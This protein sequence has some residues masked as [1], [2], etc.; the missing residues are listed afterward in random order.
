MWGRCH[1]W[2][3]SSDVRVDLKTSGCGPDADVI[4]DLI[5]RTILQ[6]QVRGCE[7]VLDRPFIYL[8]LVLI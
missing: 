6:Y 1:C 3:R 4:P 2:T 7:V 8:S 5:I